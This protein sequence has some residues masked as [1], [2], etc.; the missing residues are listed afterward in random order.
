MN[1]IK[2]YKFE[3]IFIVWFT[4]GWIS[5]F[6]EPSS[7]SNFVLN[8]N[9]FGT[10]L[11]LSSFIYG[12]IYGFIKQ[13]NIEK[14]KKQEYQILKQRVLKQNELLQEWLQTEDGQQ[15]MFYKQKLEK[16]I[17]ERM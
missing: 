9:Y 10:Y 16:Y 15:F 8:F 3:I 11:F 6:F 14:L 7:K 4:I 17:N 2:K 1:L 13:H 5:L 12:L